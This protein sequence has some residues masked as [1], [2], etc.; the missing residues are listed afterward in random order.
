VNDMSAA[1]GENP[2]WV[3]VGLVGTV[4]GPLP[5]EVPT[6]VVVDLVGTVWGPPKV[7]NSDMGSG[8]FGG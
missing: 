6:W 5:G 1:P 4:W 7:R 8:M 3:V 2:T